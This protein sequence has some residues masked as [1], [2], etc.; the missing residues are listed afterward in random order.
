MKIVVKLERKNK[1]VKEYEGYE[2]AD[3]EEIK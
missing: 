2:L 3:S 1:D